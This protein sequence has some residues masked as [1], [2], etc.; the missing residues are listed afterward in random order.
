MKKNFKNYALVWGILL[1]VFNAVVFIAK[2]IIPGYTFNYDGRFWISWVFIIVAFIGNLVCAFVAF[3]SKNNTKLFYNLSL[4]TISWTALIVMEIVGVCLML[5][6]NCP[7][8]IAA[9]ICI[10]VFAFNVITV[11][12]ARWAAETV[13]AVDEKIKTKT[14]FVKMLT[15]DAESLLAHA[16]TQEAKAACKK[17]YE[18]VRYSDPMSDEALADVESQIALKFNEFSNAVTES[19]DSIK[20][21][22]DELVVLIGDRSRKCKLLK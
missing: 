21:L 12:K 13:E 22:A 7:S 17:V 9:I 20:K 10:L 6:P 4:I 8:W 3:S 1:V 2:P 5:I 14:L 11:I 18:A 15:V 16:Q 19:A